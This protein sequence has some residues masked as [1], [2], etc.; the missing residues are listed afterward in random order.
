M[1]VAGLGAVLSGF[2]AAIAGPA[3]DAGALVERVQEWLDGTRDMQARFEQTLTSGALGTG[4]EESGRIYLERP[5]R[6]RWDYLE[7]EKKVA[8]IDGDATRL[9]LEEDQQLW[10]GRLESGSLLA[11]LL[12]DAQPLD[13]LFVAELLD[14]SGTKGAYRLR[15]VPRSDPENLREIVLT[16]RPPRFAIDEVEVLDAAGNRM[17]YRFLD[18]RRNRGVPP[19]VFHF[20][21]PPGTE[22]VRPGKGTD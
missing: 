2:P 22:I 3:L 6:M 4:L 15:L 18:L 8:L 21:P 14:P 12:A 17:R 11:M 13:T 16:L 10:E 20:E 9:Y 5:G 1:L 19:S 7:P